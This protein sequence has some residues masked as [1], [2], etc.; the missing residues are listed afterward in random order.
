MRK[1]KRA[2]KKIGIFGGTFNPVHLGH[3]LVASGIAERLSLDEVVFVP[4]ARPPHKSSGGIVSF[5]HRLRMV[6]LA[7]QKHG[8]FT[9]S[10]IEGKRYGKSYTYKTLEYFAEKY[11][12]RRLYFVMGMDAYND[13]AIW[14]NLGRIL[15]LA[16]IVVVCRG[17]VGELIPKLRSSAL[18]LRFLKEAKRLNVR[19]VEISSSEIRMRLEEKRSIRYMVPE[20]IARYI[21]KNRLYG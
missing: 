17:G 6:K 10:D 5:Q 14:K 21:K 15:D 11:S 3:L 2:M 16:K 20:V 4:C 12:G 9:A 8:I 19:A 1:K 13:L 7:V 18:R